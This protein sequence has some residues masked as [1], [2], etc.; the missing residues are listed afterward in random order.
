METVAEFDPA[1]RA[2]QAA[3]GAVV[4]PRQALVDDPFDASKKY[5]FGAAFGAQFLLDN[6]VVSTM[7][8]LFD[9]DS[10]QAGET[11]LSEPDHNPYT[12][13]KTSYD[14]DTL[15]KLAPFISD[16]SFDN[17]I[18]ARQTKTIADDLISELGLQ[19]KADASGMGAFL[20]SAAASVMDPFSWIPIIG[21]GAAVTKLGRTGI[22]AVNIA[23]TTGASELVL[24]ATQRNRQL[25]DSIMAVGTG[26]MIGGGLGMFMSARDPRSALHPK[27]PNNP[28]ALQN[29]GK[30]GET[31]ATLNGQRDVL[32]LDDLELPQSTLGA[33]RVGGG[34]DTRLARTDPETAL[35]RMARGFGDKFFNSMTPLGRVA[36]ASTDSARDLGARIFD[37]GNMLTK[38]HLKGEALPMSAESLKKFH[39][40]DVGVWTAALNTSTRRLNLDLADTL[41]RPVKQ[42]DMDDYIVHLLRPNMD[43]T[44]IESRLVSQYGEASLPHI[45]RV[46]EENTEA[47]HKL[48]Q[49]TQ[50][51]LIR[52]RLVRDDTKVSRISGGLKASRDEV[53]ALKEQI[54]AVNDKANQEYEAALK[55][56]SE[57]VRKRAAADVEQNKD[58][59][60]DRIKS[61]LKSARDTKVRQATAD[62]EDKLM[63]AREA[64]EAQ[65]TEL[66][67]EKSKPE[68]LG[69]D[70]GMA[71][72]WVKDRLIEDPDEA[73]RFLTEILTTKPDE[74]WLQETFEL[75]GDELEA[76]RT[77]V[78]PEDTTRYRD[79][80]SEWAG[81]EEYVR[82]S[83][84]ERALKSAKRDR[85]ETMLDLRNALV[86]VNLAK[87]QETDLGLSE[88][89]KRRDKLASDIREGEVRRAL[90]IRDER[91][92][93]ESATAARMQTLDRQ[94]REGQTGLEDRRDALVLSQSRNEQNLKTAIED[95]LTDP[96]TPKDAA[97]QPRFMDAG[98]VI[99]GTEK[100]AKGTRDILSAETTIRQDADNVSVKTAR[101]QGKAEEISRSIT[102][103]TKKLEYLQHQAQKIDN[104]LYAAE[105]RTRNAEFAR[106]ELDKIVS[107]ARAA[108]QIA[109][110]DL[111]KVK[112]ALL[113]EKKRPRLDAVVDEVYDNLTTSGNL[114]T[115]MLDRL[116][117][118]RTTGRA[119]ARSLRLDDN[120]QSEALKKG[121]LRDDLQ[122]V[123]YRQNEEVAAEVAIREA[124]GIGEHRRFKSWAEAEQFVKEDYDQLISH[125]ALKEGSPAEKKAYAKQKAKLLKEKDILIDD[126][127]EGISRLKG[128]FDED[129]TTHGWL[130]WGSA[131]ARQANFLRFGSTFLM[132]SLTDT[133]T[134]AL[135]HQ[136]PDIQ[137]YA[138]EAYR[139]M[140]E[141]YSDNPD[142]FQSY[143]SANEAGF[144]AAGS[145]MRRFGGDDDLLYGSLK[146]YGI[147]HGTAKQ[148][149]GAI[150][151]GGEYLSGLVSKYSGVPA[152]NR[153]WK[154]VSGLIMRD[155]IRDMT[156]GYEGLTDLQKADL[157]S[158][159]ISKKVAKD[160]DAQIKLHGKN[161]AEGRFDP[162]W[163]KWSE[164]E[165]GREAYRSYR[166]AIQRDMDLTINT[167]GIGDTPRLMSKWH[168][169][170][171]LQF[172]T[173]AFTFLNRYA[174]G[175][176]QRISLFQDRQ[177]YMSLGILM[178]SAMVVMIGADIRGGRDPME[179]FNTENIG[180]TMHEIIDRSGLLGW[181][182]PYI[183]SALKASSGLTG[184]GGNSRFARNNALD[185]LLGINFALFNDIKRASSAALSGEG[186]FVE[187]ALVLA[188]FGSLARFL[189]NITPDM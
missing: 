176:S 138:A 177:A 27:N 28:L 14:K 31:I 80:I 145:A 162:Q 123:V 37:Y 72:L 143:I 113:K 71:Q 3:T 86:S 178:G 90:L 149:T 180:S 91:A 62:L 39:M 169:K 5:G 84:A 185:S 140:K 89:R 129:G 94:K 136:L 172:Q 108:R 8:E 53:K 134:I 50:D 139:T 18:T 132:S 187:K 105:I 43:R 29:L 148:V 1:A 78:K 92:L 168:G 73:K 11:N 26:A 74:E 106:K 16:G 93:K 23:L 117:G 70:Y 49:K 189:H 30:G 34:E 77:S 67:H 58:L 179:R 128:S 13:L 47:L 156:A 155:K 69:R 51:L 119:K 85:Q 188:P 183:D 118:D 147:G 7:K 38:A 40:N 130:K 36:R 6:V 63:R 175:A 142:D 163:E 121:W 127:K 33:A 4:Y 52:E 42:Q 95:T 181:T 2:R 65:R 115:S 184:Y 9:G 103:E 116:G 15:D 166:I 160:I 99:Q 133:A 98:D 167:P 44:E 141:F 170:M 41:Q 158:L 171:W 152:W 150:D 126:L 79:I 46:A 83:Q 153:Y 100:V 57:A 55:G 164:T 17:A 161:D 112:R 114:S 146:G 32:D 48:N 12:V 87:R 97:G 124:I 22:V 20:G 19:E 157:A 75:S 122:A 109:E 144:G 101:Q 104:A 24:Q 56:R 59:D 111:N 120:Q 61:A 64:V 82:I 165:V 159:G 107:D 81:D 173:F 125:L 110:K 102:R 96:A 135:R 131:K 66:V 25:H 182:S 68:A 137:K 88:A 35:G 45:K 151:K 186:N 10:V 174:Y 54:A 154:T 21:Q 60:L 76:L